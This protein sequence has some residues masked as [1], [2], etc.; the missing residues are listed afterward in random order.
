[1]VVTRNVPDLEQG[2][3]VIASARLFHPL[4]I[5]QKGGALSEKD[6]EGRQGDVAHR[7]DAVVA[8]ATVRQGCG[9]GVQALD[10]MIESTR[11]HEATISA[12]ASKLY[13][14]CGILFYAISDSVK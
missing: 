13:L 5:A 12:R 14:V 2:V 8:G 3:G 7:V 11:I 6:A 10:E 1:M 4:L 9:H